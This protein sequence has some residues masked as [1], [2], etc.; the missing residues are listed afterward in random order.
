MKIVD[1]LPAGICD[2]IVQCARC[3][4]MMALIT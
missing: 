1:K 2:Y 3:V 4:H